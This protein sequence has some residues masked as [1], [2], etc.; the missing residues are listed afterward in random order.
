M[1]RPNPEFNAGEEAARKRI[2]GHL[3]R[4]GAPAADVLALVIWIENMAERSAKRPGGQ[5]R[6]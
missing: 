6:E 1:K 3:Q 2:I 5:G 4:L